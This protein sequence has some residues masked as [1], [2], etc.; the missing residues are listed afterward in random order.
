MSNKVTTT[1]A[2][3]TITTFNVE[4]GSSIAT[5]KIN[6]NTTVKSASASATCHITG[7]Q[8]ESTADAM[9]ENALIFLLLSQ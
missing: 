6:T 9:P 5:T 7:A 4:S 8:A 2:S 1:I 3:T